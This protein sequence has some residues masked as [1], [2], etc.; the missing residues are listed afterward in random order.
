MSL[1]VKGGQLTSAT[2]TGNQ[3]TTGIGFQPKIVFFYTTA[4][5]GDFLWSPIIGVATSSS[6]RWCS[7]S[8]VYVIPTRTNYYFNSSKCVSYVYDS[9]GAGTMTKLFEADFVTMDS[10]GFTINW[11][12]VQATGYPVNYLCLGGTDISV[13]VGVADLTSGTGNQSFTGV[14]F[15]PGAL[16]IGGSASVTSADGTGGSDSGL[17]QL[18][19]GTSSASRMVMAGNST[20]ADNPSNTTGVLDQTKIY[21]VLTAT[22]SVAGAADLSTLDSD[23][24]TLNKTTSIAATVRIGYIALGG[25]AQYKVSSITQP[26][27]T[28][29]SQAK[30]G[31]GFQPSAV[32]FISAGKTASNT[33]NASIR[34][35]IGASVSSS[36][37]GCFYTTCPDAAATNSYCNRRTTRSKALVFTGDSNDTAAAD[38]TFTSMDSDGFTVNW[39]TADATQRAIGFLAIGAATGGGGTFKSAFARN[40]NAILQ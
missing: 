4:V 24:F 14:G 16:I 17:F 21:S 40:A 36:D 27:A 6:A 34:T 1:S 39:T 11:S 3:A 20:D 9:D 22:D 35:L 33:T 10:D 12:T 28:T 26:N 37:Y 30:T 2:S 19:F 32:L 7:M 31:V 25:T 13:K 38:A 15:L 29:G 23:G 8:H 5:T 18:G